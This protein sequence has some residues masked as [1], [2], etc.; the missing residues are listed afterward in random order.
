M[1][2]GLPPPE[3]GLLHPGELPLSERKGLVG[4]VYLQAVAAL[5]GYDCTAPRSDY[6]SIDAIVSSRTGV[7]PKLEFQVKCTSVDLAPDAVDFPFNLPVKTYDD[8]RLKE[9]IVPRYLLVVVVPEAP[10]D[11]IRLNERRL[12]LRRCGYYASLRDRPA[13]PNLHSVTVRMHRANQL[14]PG[15]LGSLMRSAVLKGGGK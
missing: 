11:W 14:T 5:A 13:T 12:N 6:D 2:S 7:R 4:I 8:L 10:G 1:V 15:A 3:V 9:V